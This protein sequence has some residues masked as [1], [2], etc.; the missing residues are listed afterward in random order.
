MI[1]ALDLLQTLEAFLRD[2]VWS[3]GALI[4]RKSCLYGIRFKCLEVLHLVRET[5]VP[6]FFKHYEIRNFCVANA[7]L[8]FSTASSSSKLHTQG[9][10]PYELVI[11][12][13]AAQIK[14]CES[15]IPLQLPGLRHAIL[16]GDEKQLPAM[17]K[18]KVHNPV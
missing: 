14:E 18:S 4:G 5:P 11:I 15:S 6:K 16:V 17:V 3:K 1:G 2:T 12:D 10:A 8:I 13:E 7:F 9:M